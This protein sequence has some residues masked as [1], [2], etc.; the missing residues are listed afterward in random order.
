MG[1]LTDKLAEIRH[2]RHLS[3]ISVRCC[4]QVLE[5]VE[6]C[7]VTIELGL[8]SIDLCYLDSK[9]PW[10]HDLIPGRMEV[11]RT[12]LTSNQPATH[13]V[14]ESPDAR[15]HMHHQHVMCATHKA[16]SAYTHHHLTAQRLPHLIQG[17]GKHRTKPVPIVQVACAHHGR[18]AYRRLRRRY[19]SAFCS[20]M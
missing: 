11:V 10:T 9:A 8:P 14:R 13:A 12:D 2:N 7:E 17:D 4:S 16:R 1:Y 20:P 18:G 5:S 19:L 6:A 3:R 15:Q